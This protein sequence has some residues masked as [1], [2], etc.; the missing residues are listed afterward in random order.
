MRRSDSQQDESS[1]TIWLIV[2]LLAWWG[3]AEG[4]NKRDMGVPNRGKLH[5]LNDHP[6]ALELGGGAGRHRVRDHRMRT[7]LLSFTI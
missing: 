7:G 1:E 5:S 6:P 4:Q 2:K 3:L